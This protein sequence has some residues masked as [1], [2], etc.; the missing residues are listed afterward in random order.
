MKLAGDQVEKLADTFGELTVFVQSPLVGNLFYDLRQRAL[1]V[2][3]QAAEGANQSSG[4]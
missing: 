1:Q 3:T 4:A 2:E